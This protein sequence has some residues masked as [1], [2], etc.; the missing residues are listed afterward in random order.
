MEKKQYIAPM[1]TVVTFKVER[2]F[3]LS[4]GFGPQN[5]FLG[6]VGLETDQV[7]GYNTQGQQNWHESDYFGSGW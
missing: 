6:L 3:A 5:S 2:G 1:L 4:N 7:Q